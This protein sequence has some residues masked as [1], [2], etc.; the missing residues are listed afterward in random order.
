MGN[1]Y[2]M[3]VSKMRNKLGYDLAKELLIGHGI[4]NSVAQ[5]LLA[6]TYPNEPKTL[7]MNAIK[8]A[9]KGGLT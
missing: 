4:S 3:I 8:A 6:G 1:D 9:A 2:K 5:K 7:L